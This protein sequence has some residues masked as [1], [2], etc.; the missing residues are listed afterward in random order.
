[1]VAILAVGRPHRGRRRAS[2]ARSPAVPTFPDPADLSPDD[3]R[4]AV[5]AILAA[6]LLRL[7]DRSALRSS[8]ASPN[9]SKTLR[10]ELALPPR[11]GPTVHGG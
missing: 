6:G 11:V 7:R 1:M 8:F 3:C 2:P 10:P 4:R 9:L 5:A